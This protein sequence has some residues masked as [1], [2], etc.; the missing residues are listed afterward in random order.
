MWKDEILQIG[1]F[2]LGHNVVK[3]IAHV[4]IK[5]NE[6]NIPAEKRAEFLRKTLHQDPMYELSSLSEYDDNKDNFDWV[7]NS[8]LTLYKPKQ[9]KVSCFIDSLKIKQL[10]GQSTRDFLSA[11]RIQCQKSFFDKTLPEKEELM[12]MAF[13]HGLRNAALVKVLNEIKPETL[14][15]A[16]KLIKSEK[17]TD[18]EEAINVIKE[19]N[20]QCSCHTKVEYLMKKVKELE[21]MLTQRR[22]SFRSRNDIKCY[23]C[24]Q[25]GH[26]ARTCRKK[27]Y[28]RHCGKPGHISENCNQRRYTRG[29]APVRQIA[30]DVQSNVSEPSS[31]HVAAYAED[32]GDERQ[33]PTK[34]LYSIVTAKKTCTPPI[35]QYPKSVVSWA[36]YINNQ[37]S[38]PR[39]PLDS[40]TTISK[41]NKE[42][43][44]NKPVITA[45]IGSQD[46]NVLL[47]TGSVGNV[48]DYNFLA[49]LQK[50]GTPVKI[51]RYNGA[52]KC[53]NG[54]DLPIIGYTLLPV[55]VGYQSHLTK[56]IVVK[57]IFPNVILG[58]SFMQKSGLSVDPSNMCARIKQDSVPFVSQRKQVN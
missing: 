13:T 7:K 29:P 16:Y 34:E 28:C 15:E 11:V 6:L 31:E 45:R 19:D 8:L 4:E 41:S 1:L 51:L 14:D 57:A 22:N 24:G 55:K 39:K 32:F 40:Y 36:Q 23:N 21:A 38:K 47:D 18:D 44:R 53:A 12:I 2:K 56:F 27:P 17:L 33:Q 25:S 43:A 54:S 35:K 3:H 46:K 58:M 30:E 10:P 5:I 42:S 37:G 9:S 49:S 20:T 52:L 26:I 48:I 50:Q